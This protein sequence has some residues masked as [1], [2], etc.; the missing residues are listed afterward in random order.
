[1]RL[2]GRWLLA[3]ALLLACG[4]ADAEPHLAA[5]SGLRCSRCHVSPTGGGKRTAYGAL[6]AQAELTLQGGRPLLAPPGP[7]SASGG[8]VLLATLPTGEVTDWLAVGADLRLAN[9]TTFLDEKKNSFEATAGALYLE[10]R[11]WAD[12]VVLYLDEE[13]AVAGAR[14]REAWG[15]V[16][17]P[18][19]TY[20]RGGRLLPPFGL[21][22]VDDAAYTRRVTGANF[23]N[24]DL[25][26]EVGLDKGPI[27]AAVALTNGSFT[28]AD[29]D[30]LKALWGM[31]E[32]HLPRF[33][34][35]L[36]GAWNPSEAGSR[37]MAGIHGGL[38][39]AR[40]YA[41]GEVDFIAE[42]PPDSARWS[43]QLA[44]LVEA[45]VVLTKGLFL[46]ASW[47][48]NDMNLELR[49]DRRQRFRF[50]LDLFPLRGLAARLGYVLQQSE[51]TDPL[52]S[53]DRLEVIL[54][55]Y[56]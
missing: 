17:G 20:L 39:L 4:R 1:L 15:L 22:I 16:R 51:T 14:N 45:G 6:Y 49:Q 37:G 43:Y 21:R 5:L 27:F 28:A 56:L 13:L 2:P 10:L 23:A 36:S 18:W 42:R 40:F 47:D 32:L 31:I 41:Q 3:L 53:A 9:I 35:G 52:D 38:R 8:A 12:R 24:P 29:T 11:P 25:G 50:G 55:V 19:G 46:R 44:A 33:H 26:L 54:H 34:L 48:V 7:S 30:T